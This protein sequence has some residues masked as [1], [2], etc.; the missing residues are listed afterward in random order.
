VGLPAACTT[1]VVLQAA[2]CTNNN[3]NKQQQC[4]VGQRLGAL[5]H[6]YGVNRVVSTHKQLAKTTLPHH[7]RSTTAS[8]CA[9]TERNRRHESDTSN[10]D[11]SG[12][13]MLCAALH[14]S[15]RKAADY[16][17]TF[18]TEQGIPRSDTNCSGNTTG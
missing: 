2:G 10:I 8:A 13:V 6:P 1:A 15:V 18:A 16:W 9:H 4:L 17:G 7:N 5:A 11:E 3:S 14:R 12:V